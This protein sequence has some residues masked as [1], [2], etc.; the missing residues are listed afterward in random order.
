MP[1]NWRSSRNKIPVGNSH[2]TPSQRKNGEFSPIIF[3]A[4]DKLWW[5]RPVRAETKKARDTAAL[6]SGIAPAQRRIATAV[7]PRR[8]LR[9]P[10]APANLPTGFVLREPWLSPLVRG[11]TRQKQAHDHGCFHEKNRKQKHVRKTEPA[12]APLG[13]GRKM[14]SVEII[15]NSGGQICCCFHVFRNEQRSGR[16]IRSCFNLRGIVKGTLSNF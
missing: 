7:H 13:D 11:L 8:G 12:H 10:T 2:R 16:A 1:A 9:L 3:R 6:H 5:R 15:R 4:G 14:R